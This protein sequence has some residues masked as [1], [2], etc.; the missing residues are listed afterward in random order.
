LYYLGIPN[1][2]QGEDP[3]IPGDKIVGPAH[4][5]RCQNWNIRFITDQPSISSFVAFVGAFGYPLMPHQAQEQGKEDGMLGKLSPEHFVRLVDH[6]VA[7]NQFQ[8]PIYDGVQQFPF[9]PGKN[10]PRH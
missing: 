7:Q 5:R 2:L 10:H 8:F 3:L 6:V 4:S 9:V 1:P